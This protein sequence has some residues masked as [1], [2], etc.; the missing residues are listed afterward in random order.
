MEIEEFTF[1]QN[2]NASVLYQNNVKY[3]VDGEILNDDVLQGCPRINRTGHTGK[4]LYKLSEFNFDILC[5]LE[6]LF[7]LVR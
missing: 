6:T 5:S 7:C 4:L 2:N 3:S 1:K